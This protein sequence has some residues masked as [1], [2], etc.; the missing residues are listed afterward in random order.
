[1]SLK[2]GASLDSRTRRGRGLEHIFIEVA[3]MLDPSE[4]DS[5]RE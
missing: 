2:A 1:M 4:G 3:T 5:F